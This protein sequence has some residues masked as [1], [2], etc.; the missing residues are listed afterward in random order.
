MK[1]NLLLLVVA[2]AL[3]FGIAEM[4][5]RLKGVYLSYNER[6]GAGGYTSPFQT[7]N[8]GWTHRYRPSETRLLKRN[9]FTDSWT[10]NEDGLKEKAFRLSKEENR[11]L[12]LGDSYAEG[13]GAPPDSA[14]PR[15][16]ES[17][18][19]QH[20]DSQTQ[21][22][23]GGIGGSDVFFAYKLLLALAPK[24]KPGTVVLTC[25]PSDIPEYLTRGGFERFVDDDHLQYKSGPWFE[26]FYAHSL[27]VRLIVHDV[28]HFDFNFIPQKNYRQEVIQAENAMCGAIDSFQM[29]CNIHHLPFA[30]VFHPFYPDIQRPQEYQMKRMIAHCRE[31][32]IRCTDELPYLFHRGITKDNWQSIY[33]PSDGHFKSSGYELLAQCVYEMAKTTNQ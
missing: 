1:K 12:I 4:A 21:V 26:F 13:V 29:Y 8:R 14:Y 32:N 3:S 30:V 9:E 10:A 17:L 31:K 24:Y 7:D 20:G 11:L 27:L 28:L 16:L 15:I 19:R 5:C 22:I 25:N 33:W 23:N 18:F 6:T 2:L